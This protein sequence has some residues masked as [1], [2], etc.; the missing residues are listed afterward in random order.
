MIKLSLLER[1]AARY[2]NVQYKSLKIKILAI[3]LNKMQ[4]ESGGNRRQ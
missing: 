3:S 1:R 2:L 4:E